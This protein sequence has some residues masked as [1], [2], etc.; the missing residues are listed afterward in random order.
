MRA[1]AK[2]VLIVGGGTAGWLTAGYLART[3]GADLPGGARITLVESPEIGIIGVGEGTFPTIRRTLA[4]IGVPEKELLRRCEATFKQGVKFVDWLRP[5]GQ[6]TQA[7]Y[8]HGFQEADDRK[9][10][11]EYLPYWLL[12]EAGDTPW[13][14]ASTPQKR[15]VDALRGPK[16][17]SHPEYAGVMNYAFHFDAGA[18]AELL[19]DQSVANGVRHISDTV[20]DV[21]CTEDGAISGV[22][23]QNHGVQEADLYIDCTGFRAELIGKALGQ[24]WKSCT[25]VLFCDSAIAAQVP[26]GAPD[27]PIQSATLSTARDAGW[28]WDIGLQTRRGTGYVYSSAH[29]EPEE[30]ERTLRSYLGAQGEAVTTRRLRFD[31]GYREVNWHKNCV[32]VGL[33]SGFFEPLEATG[34][35]FSEIAAGAIANLFP[36]AG[37]Y[38]TSAR[39]FNAIMLQRYERARDFLKLHYSLTRRVDSDFWIDNVRRETIPDSLLELLDR[40]RHRPPNEK[41]FNPN[42]DVFP[43]TSWQCVLYGMGWKTDLSAQAG[44]MRLRA[45]AREAFEQVRRQS[46]FAVENLPDNR[47]LLRQMLA[48]PAG[49]TVQAFAGAAG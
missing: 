44:V 17:A 8:L 16:L 28:I 18:L 19:R 6:G 12:G 46:G 25:D 23:T 1:E 21:F 2:Q 49:S 14:E 38:E 45:E 10:G 33:S 37:D 22:L 30:A 13:D 11:P 48:E 42:I 3:L 40:W 5:A 41:D 15:T 34:I 35:V 31:A 47:A 27:T 36:W 4:R 29:C 24:K 26:Y 32:A 39:Q 7:N 43:A 9:G 20:V